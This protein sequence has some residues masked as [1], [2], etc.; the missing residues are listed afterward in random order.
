MET[1][2]SEAGFWYGLSL[3]AISAVFG[4]TLAVLSQPAALLGHQIN[5]AWLRHRL[6][7]TRMLGVLGRLGIGLNE[8]SDSRSRA[9]L[10]GAL[11]NCS[12]CRAA[13]RCDRELRHASP[14]E[15]FDLSFCPNRA[16]IQTFAG[17][18]SAMLR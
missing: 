12:G 16:A 14:G 10:R 8:F 1:M 5:R 18:S 17:R 4:V 2:L 3:V 11:N 15:A 9:E 6:A 7:Q 13:E